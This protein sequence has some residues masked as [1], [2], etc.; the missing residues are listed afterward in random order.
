MKIIFNPFIL[1]FIFIIFSCKEFDKK[2]RQ[3]I[4]DISKVT[5]AF[6][7]FGCEGRCPF[8]ALSI[9]SS[10][11]A[12]Y[13]G[14]KYSKKNGFYRGTIDQKEWANIQTRFKKFIEVGIGTTQ[15]QS[16]D[17]PGV[18]F[19]INTDSKEFRF[20]ENTGK[21]AKKDLDILYWYIQLVP[22]IN[23]LKKT[24]SLAFDTSIQFEIIKAE[25]IVE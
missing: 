20:R 23:K 15:Y 18:E 4:S 7:G 17:Y 9:D 2:E 16:T 19:L 13:F 24:D 10:L 3:K 1:A 8:Q 14:G 12:Q 25:K 11:T 6:T 21:I 22:Q 5:V